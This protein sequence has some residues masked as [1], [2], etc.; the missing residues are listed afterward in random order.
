MINGKAITLGGKEFTIPPVPF[1]TLRKFSEIFEGREKPS[2]PQMGEIIYSAVKRN[3]PDLTQNDF[4]ENYLDISNMGE[5]FVQVMATAGAESKT[6][7]AL[8]GNP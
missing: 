8:P 7:E 1:T 3:Y 2:L 4:E 6:G 5:T